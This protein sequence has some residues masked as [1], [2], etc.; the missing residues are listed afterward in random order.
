MHLA[1]HQCMRYTPREAADEWRFSVGGRPVSIPVQPVFAAAED[2]ALRAAALAGM[3]LAI[4]P[5]MFLE[6]DLAAGRL[7]SVLD[8]EMWSS[9]RIVHAVI[10]EGRMAPPQVGKFVDALTRWLR[11]NGYSQT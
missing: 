11:N 10:V 1:S 8:A 6:P 9:Q 2:A 5:R 7:V 4:M 3:G